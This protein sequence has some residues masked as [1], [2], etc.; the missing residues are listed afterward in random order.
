MSQNLP[1]ATLPYWLTETIEI[2]LSCPCLEGL[3]T[4]NLKS[5]SDL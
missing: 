2:G 1:K 4:Q 3:P 5:A